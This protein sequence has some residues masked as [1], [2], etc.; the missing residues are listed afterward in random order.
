MGTIS[1]RKAKAMSPAPDPDK[2]RAIADLVVAVIYLV[3]EVLKH[4][5][6]GGG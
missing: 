5:L 4:L 1:K 6:R 3:I 2:F